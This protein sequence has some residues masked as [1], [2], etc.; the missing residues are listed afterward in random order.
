MIISIIIPIFNRIEVTKVG[1]SLL[2]ASIAN[3]PNSN[4]TCNFEVVVVDDGS[5]DGS[6]EWI[7]ENHPSV[8]ILK[9]DGNLWWSGAINVGSKYSLETLQADYLLLW[10][11]DVIPA[12]EYFI[13]ISEIISTTYLENTILG[14]KIMTYEQP[15]LIWALGGFFNK[16]SGSLGMIVEN[17]NLYG[18]NIDCDWLNGMGTLIPSTIIL[19]HNLWWDE[20]RFPQYH[21]D[22]DF[23]LRC[24]KKGVKITTSLNLTIYNRTEFTGLT[25]K[26]NWKEFWNGL[27]SIRSFNNVKKD[28]LFYNIHGVFPIAY[29]TMVK[30]YSLYIGGFIKNHVLGFAKFK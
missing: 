7:R 13:N 9:G 2:Y 11:D 10:N 19:K 25:K 4:S 18:S 5:T 1:L 15:H 17:N 28:F 16:F 14:S 3:V 24:K 8:H 29:I 27:T 12:D 30:K 6:S 20:V 21:G 22:S 26:E 23:T